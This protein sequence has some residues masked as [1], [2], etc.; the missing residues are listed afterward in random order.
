MKII[1]GI[2]RGNRDILKC[3]TAAGSVFCGLLLTAAICWAGDYTDHGDGTV[4]DN[5][6]GLMWQQEDDNI[7]RNWGNALNYCESLVL[8]PD[9]YND[10][11]LS[12]VRELQSIT[13][14]DR[15]YPAIDIV[16]FPGTNLSI[17]WTSTTSAMV[18]EGAWGVDFKD[19][20]IYDDFS[21]EGSNYV[22]CVRGGQ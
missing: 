22:R 2:N 4:T 20:T 7:S 18:P 9:G 1:S 14:E 10:W 8:P 17:Y 11:R 12:N 19:V 16:A 13:E 21:K 3:R 15:A 5:N 6:T